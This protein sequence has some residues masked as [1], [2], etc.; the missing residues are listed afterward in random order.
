MQFFQLI[1]SQ[2]VIRAIKYLLGAI[3]KKPLSCKL[4][5]QGGIKQHQS[6]SNFLVGALN[7]H[8]MH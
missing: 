4:R 3:F 2:S 5:S 7:S 6:F 8:L 1:F